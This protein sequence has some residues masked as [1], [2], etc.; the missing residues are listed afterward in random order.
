[1][2][3]SMRTVVSIP[4]PL[5]DMAETL[6]EELGISRSELYARALSDYIAAHTQEDITR[7]LDEICSSGDGAS[8]PVLAQL[9][10]LSLVK[11]EW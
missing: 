7:R 4:T 1:M 11:E 6:A 5:F 10:W 3:N 8:D 2:Q 9:Q